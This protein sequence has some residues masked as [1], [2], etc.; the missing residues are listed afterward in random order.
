MDGFPPERSMTRPSAWVLALSLA[1]LA[2]GFVRGAATAEEPP[3][4]GGDK[5]AAPPEAE[6]DDGADDKVPFVEEVNKAIELGVAWLKAK[7]KIYTFKDLPAAH[8]GLVKGQQNYGGGND[9]AYRHP[10]GPTALALY[11]LL[12]CGVDP[13]D[14]VI[15]EGFHWL[16]V[17]HPITEETDGAT[18]LDGYSWT[19]TPAVSAYELSVMILALTAKYDH[20]KRGK[21]SAEGVRK[22]KLKITDKDDLEWLHEMVKLLVE[23]RGMPVE[24]AAPADMRGWRYNVPDY[25]LSGGNRTTTRKVSPG[26]IAN[27]DLSSTQ[28]AALAL[29]SAHRFGAKVDPDV[30][31][32]VLE[33]ALDHQEADGP[34]HKRHDP[35]YAQGGYA[36]PT[37]KA[38]GFMYIK[39]SPEKSEG[40]ATGSMTA[41]GLATILIAK[42]VLCETDKGRKKFVEQKLDRTVE[43]A[44]YDA[45]AWHDRNWSPFNNPASQAG[46][47]IYYLYSLERAMDILNKQLVGK[48][49]WYTEGARKI[50]DAGKKVETTERV[51]R[52]TRPVPGMYW[53]TDATHEP[54]DVLD[55]CFA[56]LFLKRATKGLVPSGP[57]TG[58]D[59]PAAD[60]R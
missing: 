34:D 46:Y 38:R 44:T 47:H 19:H 60:N 55:T 11:T 36:Q 16:K 8:W 3:A 30:W 39:G 41:C 26:H 53:N 1:A 12:K 32:Q 37:D 24:G 28:L 33:F 29:Y 25:P 2:L 31:W 23:R 14:P 35:G 20:Y 56:L 59:G 22:G 45:L 27:Q 6:P 57:V 21:N 42:E 5:P 7:P 4:A 50:L 58:G 10:A 43:K 40:K 48:H 51:K 13:K 17:L 9:P 15:T 49:L 18:G 52:G 54:K